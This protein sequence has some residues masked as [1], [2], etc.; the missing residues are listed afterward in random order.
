MRLRVA[1]LVKRLSRHACAMWVLVVSVLLSF[2][3]P[4]VLV[5]VDAEGGVNGVADIVAR[6]ACPY[7]R[8]EGVPLPVPFEVRW[9]H[10]AGESQRFV[11]DPERR[12]PGVL[13]ICPEPKPIPT[14]SR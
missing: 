10:Q 5:Y 6:E 13:T 14:E 4:Q 3:P 2:D 11:P 7:L 9:L 1:N 12:V 8:A